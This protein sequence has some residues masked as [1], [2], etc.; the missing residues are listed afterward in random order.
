MFL[1]QK[2]LEPQEGQSQFLGKLALKVFLFDLKENLFKRKKVSGGAFFSEWLEGVPKGTARAEG[3]S[4]GKS[5][6]SP[7]WRTKHKIWEIPSLFLSHNI[8]EETWC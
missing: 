2:G 1:N 3:S 7:S 4:E 8:M 5:L 6:Q